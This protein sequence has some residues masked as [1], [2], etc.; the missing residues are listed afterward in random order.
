M[1]KRS[2]GIAAGFSFVGS[3]NDDACS[4]EARHVSGSP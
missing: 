1:G 4:C 3:E 2:K